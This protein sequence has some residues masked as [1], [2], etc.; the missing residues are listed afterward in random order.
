[1]TKL[2]PKTKVRVHLKDGLTIQGFLVKARPSSGHYHLL[3][4]KVLTEAT[5]VETSGD[6]FIPASNVSFLEA[7]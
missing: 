4:P 3:N 2:K 6:V 1:M 5:T 7:V